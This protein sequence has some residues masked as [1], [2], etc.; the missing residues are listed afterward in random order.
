MHRPKEDFCNS[1]ATFAFRIDKQQTM[2]LQLFLTF[3]KI[4][5]FTF[6]GGYAMIPLIRHEIIERRRWVLKEEF[7]ELL[8]LAQSAPGPIALNTAIFVGYRTGGYRGAF[9]ALMGIVLPSFTTILLVAIFF[10]NIRENEVVDA[11][12]RAMRP[13]VVAL[14]IAPLIGLVRQLNIWGIVAAVIA[15]IILWQSNLSPIILLIVAAAAGV[16]W[17]RYTI[18]RSKREEDKR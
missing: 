10:A 9:A 6:G 14:I 3:L 17:S 13:A 5:A 2:V 7:L 8:T 15:T 12:F 11:A 4:G 1:F 16:A 18:H